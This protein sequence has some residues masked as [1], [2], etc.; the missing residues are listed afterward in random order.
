MLSKKLRKREYRLKSILR[1][2]INPDLFGQ[3]TTNLSLMKLKLK[4]LLLVNLK[5]KQM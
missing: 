1:R 3:K 4:V 2:L 5:S